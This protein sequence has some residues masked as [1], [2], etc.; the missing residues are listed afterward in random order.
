M[1]PLYNQLANY[2][3]CY[4]NRFHADTEGFN[5]RSSAFQLEGVEGDVY[6]TDFPDNGSTELGTIR[7]FTF[8]GNTAN[9]LI[10]MQVE[11]ITIKERLFS[12]L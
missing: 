4:G 12:I 8:E 11:F 9:T 10:Q 5:I 6:L 3:I 7:F 1:T 2:E